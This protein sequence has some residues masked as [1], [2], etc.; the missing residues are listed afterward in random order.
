MLL[1]MWFWGEDP[2][3]IEAKLQCRAKQSIGKVE[4]R[5]LRWIIEDW[6]RFTLVAAPATMIVLVLGIATI[7][8]AVGQL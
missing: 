6:L 5:V 4:Y 7:I 1:V 8:Y 3:K 2:L